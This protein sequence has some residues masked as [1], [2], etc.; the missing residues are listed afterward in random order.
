[1]DSKIMFRF[2]LKEDIVWI[3]IL[4][5]HPRREDKEGKAKTG[6]PP[7]NYYN[8]KHSGDFL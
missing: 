1:M 8:S 2:L 3:I 5:Y 6:K 7:G 4:K